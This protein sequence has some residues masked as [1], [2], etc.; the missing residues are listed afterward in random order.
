MGAA[1]KI[2]IFTLLLA[3]LGCATTVEAETL[4]LRDCLAKASAKNHT[5][6]VAAYDNRLAQENIVLSRSGYLPKVDFKG[7]YTAQLEPQSIQAF[8]QT[9][10]TQEADYGF[11]SLS[12]Y[13][14]LYDFGRTQA[15]Y[16]RAKNLKEATLYNYSGIEKDVFLQVIS[17][18]FGI[19]EE[20]KLLEAA[21]E[22]VTQMT[23][24]LKVANNL[25]DQGVVT[26]ND[27]LQAEV[28]LSGSK[29]RRLEAANR[30]DNAWLQLNFLTG[31]SLGY[32]ADLQEGARIETSATD[33]GPEKALMNR[34]EIKA[35]KKTI[36]ANNQEV[37]ENKGK[38]FPELFAKAG[39]DYV[40][41][42]TVKEQAIWSATAGLK[43]NLFDGFATTARYRQAILNRTRNEEA[44][45][46][47]EEGIRLEY[48][49]A[50]NDAR[51]ALERIGVSEKAI[52]QGEENLRINK[53]RYLALV[54]TATDVMDAQ[55]L[56]TQTKT[57]YYRAT[58]DYQVALARVKK[59]LGEL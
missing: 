43:I 44:L 21:N 16:D 19:L 55:T 3:G 29:Q 40:Q 51:V 59:A 42:N 57:E 1:M 4:T 49:A 25:F 54:G 9:I 38:Y 27:V 28:R 50:V 32:R 14:T 15:R 13:Q 10:A 12:I 56:L 45:R 22:E 39:V 5:L 35:L 26:R 37:K 47:M 34:A 11:F 7:G 53:D 36:E 30:L 18:Y 2:I 20:Q 8:N 33:A 46:Q 23:D 48:Q 41:N 58:F 17:A 31:Q 24:H 52:Q 6:K